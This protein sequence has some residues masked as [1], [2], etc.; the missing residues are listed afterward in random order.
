M[1]QHR[2]PRFRKTAAVAAASALVIRR[3]R[4][5]LVRRRHPPLRHEWSLPGGRLEPGETSGAAAARELAEETGIVALRGC[6]FASV[7]VGRGRRMFRIVCFRV[8]AWRGRA[9]AG[10]DAAAVAWVPLRQ[11]RRMVLRPQTLRVIADGARLPARSRCIPRVI[12]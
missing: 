12:G 9:R 7:E 11:L 10:D 8:A 3:G 4:V 1:R 5:L 6:A 2:V